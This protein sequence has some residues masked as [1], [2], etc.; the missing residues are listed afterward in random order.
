MRYFLAI[1]L[2]LIIPLQSTWAV[3]EG[4][5]GHFGN[6]AS[7]ARFHSH[8]NDHDTHVVELVGH[9]NSVAGDTGNGHNDDGHHVSHSHPI[10][11]SLVIEPNLK[12]G[13][14]SPGDPPTRLPASFTSHIPPL[15]DRPPSAR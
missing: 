15:F 4:L 8:A 10:F 13:E 14:A 5:Y 3:A 2:M 9:D 6:D 11:S 1:V 12:L 7:A